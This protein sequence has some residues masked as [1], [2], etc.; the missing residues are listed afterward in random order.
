MTSKFKKKKKKKK[1]DLSGRALPSGKQDEGPSCG[2]PRSCWRA[3]GVRCAHSGHQRSCCHLPPQAQ[4][5]EGQKQMRAVGGAR[6]DAVPCPCQQ[7]APP[8]GQSFARLL[9]PCPA[10]R[11]PPLPGPW[12]PPMQH[13]WPPLD[14][15]HPAATRL[16]SRAVKITPRLLRSR[17]CPLP[18]LTPPSQQ[19]D[20]WDW[21]TVTTLP[22]RGS[23]LPLAPVSRT[24]LGPAPS[25]LSR[26][27]RL[28]VG[29]PCRGQPRCVGLTKVR[30]LAGSA[31]PDGWCERQCQL[32]GGCIAL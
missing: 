24:V 15:L 27:T 25:V 23:L 13:E 18:S 11:C 30:L 1:G 19:W 3:V 6:L 28:P 10:R 32:Q 21:D 20:S 7:P 8:R 26:H 31:A 14:C 16:I 29:V 9:P 5:S 2:H 17:L 12:G 22:S 4:A